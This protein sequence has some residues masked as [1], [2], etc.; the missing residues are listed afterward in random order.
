MP[1]FDNNKIMEHFTLTSTYKNFLKVYS[2][3]VSTLSKSISCGK[4]KGRYKLVEFMRSAVCDS[5]Q[6]EIISDVVA[7]Q[8]KLLLSYLKF[9]K[10]KK[11]LVVGLGNPDIVA[12]SFGPLV[13]KYLSGQL[14]CMSALPKT[15][16]ISPDIKEKTGFETFDVVDLL[17]QSENVDLII[18]VDTLS[19]ESE[20]RIATSIQLSTTGI[21]PG[22][23]VGSNKKRLSPEY[24]SAACLSIGIPLM[25]VKN[26]NTASYITT[27]ANIDLAARKCAKIVAK[28][29]AI[30]LYGKGC[31]FDI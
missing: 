13:I 17:A 16:L 30:A 28:S 1:I 15:Y 31:K 18:V 14:S 20:N 8:M 4:E 27:L 6:S 24:L 10:E 12:D 5:K 19:T 9:T 11:V 29:I 7:R 26:S 21:K 3:N 22:G 25:S 2:L 23:G